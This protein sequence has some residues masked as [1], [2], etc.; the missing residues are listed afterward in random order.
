MNDYNEKLEI[1]AYMA[2]NDYPFGGK[3]MDD[4]C[5]TFTV[6]D[7]RFLCSAWIGEDPTAYAVGLGR[8]K[9]FEKTFKKV[10][11]SRR[12][13]A[14]ISTERGKERRKMTEWYMNPELHDEDFAELADLLGEDEEE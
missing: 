12:T 10:L 2:E 13:C 1:L 9:K 3:T 4:Y 6:E 7:L 11:T 5:K 8:L 14:I